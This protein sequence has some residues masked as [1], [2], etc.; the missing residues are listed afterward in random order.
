M[1]LTELVSGFT[2]NPGNLAFGEFKMAGLAKLVDLAEN[3]VASKKPTKAMEFSP[4]VTQFVNI[5]GFLET[6][7][8]FR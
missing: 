7:R 1:P 3:E 8:T 5:M 4:Q 2:H 6:F